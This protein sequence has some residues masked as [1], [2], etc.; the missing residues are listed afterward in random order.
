MARTKQRHPYASWERGSNENGN[1]MIRRFIA[2]GR[3]IATFSRERIRQIE[4]WINR[5]PRKILQ[6]QSAEERY[7]TELA[8]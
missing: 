8:A 5:Y 2:K 4:E 7:I 3:D 6:F 1:R